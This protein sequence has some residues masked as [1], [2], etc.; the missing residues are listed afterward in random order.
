MK[1][2]ISDSSV[3]NDTGAECFSV[4][5]HKGLGMLN[6]ARDAYETVTPEEEQVLHATGTQPGSAPSDT[7]IVGTETQTEERW[8]ETDPHE[9]D[10]VMCRKIDF[11]SYPQLLLRRWMDDGHIIVYRITQEI[12]RKRGGVNI[13]SEEGMD[14]RLDARDGVA[15][16]HLRLAWYPTSRLIPY[17]HIASDDD[18]TRLNG[19]RCLRQHYYRL[20]QGYIIQVGSVELEVI[21]DRDT[22]SPAAVCSVENR[23]AAAGVPEVLMEIIPPAPWI[24]PY[25][26]A[27][28][29]AGRGSVRNFIPHLKLSVKNGD[30]VKLRDVNKLYLTKDVILYSELVELEKVV[31]LGSAGNAYFRLLGDAEGVESFHLAIGSEHPGQYWIVD[32]DTRGGTFIDGVRCEPFKHYALKEGNLLLL[33]EVQLDVSFVYRTEY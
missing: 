18:E 20:Y 25:V 16:F 10:Y 29:L 15:L 26:E 6:K 3:K 21:F 24:Q 8:A 30:F 14:I 9:Y 17:I 31:E 2:K 19:G 33:G 22:P 12:F 23:E 11:D 7:I 28:R 4:P 5:Y 13:G 27:C 32:N 1:G